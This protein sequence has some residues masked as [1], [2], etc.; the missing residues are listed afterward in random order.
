MSVENKNIIDLISI[1][2]NGNVVL[3]ISDHLEWDIEN[4]HLLILQDKINYYLAAIEGDVLYEKYP[5][6]IGRN[7]IIRVAF[8]YNPNEQG[9]IFLARIKDALLAAGYGF[10]FSQQNFSED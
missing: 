2:P 3:S 1:D 7:I 10:Q 5:D 4:E 9:E 8:L 6:A